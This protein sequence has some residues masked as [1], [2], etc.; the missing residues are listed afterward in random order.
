[1]EPLILTADEAAKLLSVSPRTLHTM[2]KA[3][4]IPCVRIGKS[5]VR[6][7]REDLARFVATA[8]GPWEPKVIRN[9]NGRRKQLG[10]A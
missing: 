2:T 8:S 3:G 6:Y 4:S 10:G 7:S 5:G 1:M 9:K